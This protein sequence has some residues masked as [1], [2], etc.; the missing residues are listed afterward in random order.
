MGSE[1]SAAIEAKWVEDIPK[2]K[3]Q[4]FIREILPTTLEHYQNA[5]ILYNIVATVKS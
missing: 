3:L 4:G 1:I 2:G 5:E